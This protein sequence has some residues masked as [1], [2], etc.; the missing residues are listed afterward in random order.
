LSS[1]FRPVRSRLIVR[2][3]ALLTVALVSASCGGDVPRGVAATVDGAEITRDQLA[4]WVRAAIDD[5]P[6]LDE[7]AV[8]RDLLSRAIQARIVAGVLE[9]RGLSVTEDDL[10]AVRAQ[11]IDEVGGEERLATTLIEIG[12]PTDFYDQVFVAN[13]AAIDVLV[14]D[15]A[16][17]RVLETRTARHILVETAEEADEI[18]ALLAEGADFAQLALERSQDPGSAVEG[19]SL[20]ARERGVFVPEFDEAVWSARLDVVLA[21]VETQFGF[22]VIEVVGSE[23]RTADDLDPGALRQLVTIELG[24]IIGAAV[25]ATEVLIA[26][27][28][29]TWDAVN[30]SV[31]AAAAFGTG[32]G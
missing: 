17:G 11:I 2:V 24:D 29:G 20:G 6:A 16:Q 9:A 12:F 10:E 28:L 26:S 3:A 1:S 31:I 22:H 27:N 4:G 8:Q 13:E 21:P 18:V 30:G 5:N 14:R 19:G 15:L 25:A 23:R 7:S 32:R